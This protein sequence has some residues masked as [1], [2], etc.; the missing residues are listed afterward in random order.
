MHVRR[1][2]K[3]PN[4]ITASYWFIFSSHEMQRNVLNITYNFLVDHGQPHMLRRK[5]RTTIHKKTHCW[6]NCHTNKL[7]KPRRDN[8]TTLNL[9]NIWALSN[10]KGMSSQSDQSRSIL[11]VRAKPKL[12]RITIWED[13]GAGVGPFPWRLGLL[14]LKA[15]WMVILSI[16]LCRSSEIFP[17]GIIN[18]YSGKNPPDLRASDRVT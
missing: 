13:W 12:P 3:E 16:I 14:T 6:N 7:V 9:R 18:S 8:N 17:L 4:M 5:L 1:N 2:E 15:C 11:F 10:L